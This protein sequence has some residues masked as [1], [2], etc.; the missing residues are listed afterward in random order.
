MNTN[1]EEMVKEKTRHIKAKN[2]QLAEVAFANAHEVRVSLTRILGLLHLT[3]I[4]TGR[5]DAYLE[6]ITEEGP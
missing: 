2:K 5:K 1:L 3:S 4:D 6:I